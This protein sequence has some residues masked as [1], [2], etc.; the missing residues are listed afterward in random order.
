MVAVP[1]P[2]ELA[3]YA[4]CDYWLTVYRRTWK[5]TVVSSFVTP[6]LYV[7]AMGVLLGGF[8]DAATRPSSRARRRTSRSS[9]PGLLAAQACRRR[10]A[11]RPTR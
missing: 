7:L 6:L 10:S 9:R 5:G 4:S 11:R 2:F 8:V 1:R 3:R